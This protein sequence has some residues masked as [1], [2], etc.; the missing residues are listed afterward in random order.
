V[1]RCRRCPGRYSPDLRWNAGVRAPMSQSPRCTRGGPTK[2]G[3]SPSLVMAP[4]APPSCRVCIARRTILKCGAFGAAWV[5]LPAC[6]QRP[7]STDLSGEGGAGGTTQ[8]GAGGSPSVPGSGGAPGSGGGAG[9]R[10]AG[11]G[12]GGAPVTGCS[13]AALAVGNAAAIAVGNLQIVGG[14]IV[15]G[16]DAGGLYAMSNVCTH[17]G[18][19]VGVI[20]AAGQETLSCPCHGSGFDANGAVTRGPARAPL[21]H[22][23]ITSAADGSLSVCVGSIVAASTRTPLP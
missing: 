9:G 4:T 22:Y 8:S 19:A 5:A 2:Q 11:T 12:A 21:A 6:D 17:Q 23:Q 14:Q 13:G 20:G 3:D 18:C 15:L 7:L 16:R 10:D 1:S